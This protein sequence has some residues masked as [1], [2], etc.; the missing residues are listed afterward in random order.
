M[1]RQRA[2]EL[3]NKVDALVS[4]FKTIITQYQYNKTGEYSIQNQATK[5]IVIGRALNYYNV[6]TARRMA[7]WCDELE[8]HASKIG[9]EVE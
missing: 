5:D 7:F 3:K 2:E 4:K 8:G 6:A 1:D 9:V